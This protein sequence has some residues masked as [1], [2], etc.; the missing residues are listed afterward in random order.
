MSKV[1][2]T[3]ALTGAVTSRLQTPYVP[4]TKEEIV[5]EAVRSEAAGASIVHIHLR[6]AAG[7]PTLDREEFIELA[8]GIRSRT[9]L[10]LCISTSSWGTES[11]IEERISGV[12]AKPELVSFHV[13]STNRGRQLFSNTVEYQEALI[14][15]MQSHLVKPEFEI[16]DLGQLSR[17]I[18]IHRTHL[19]QDPLYVQFVLGTSSG[20]PALP[21]HLIHMVES[22][23][24][25]TEW[26]I[27][28]VGRAQLPMNMMGLILGGHV[29]TGLEDNIYLK[30]KLL[31]SSNALLVERIAS[32]ARELGR[33][34][35]SAEE[36]REI[37]STN[38][39]PC[40][41]SSNHCCDHRL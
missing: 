16:F 28:A 41:S 20:C 22:L 21:R 36:A 27:A 24:P 31:A 40:E 14:K 38:R 18:E 5:E 23:P 8:M 2:I 39:V 11:T 1:I 12:F 33:E 3:A 6:D 37:L 4:F 9:K 29:R 32:M 26:S 10:L 17:A 15:A 35:A 19:K 34:P 7:R 30:E 13:N 25:G